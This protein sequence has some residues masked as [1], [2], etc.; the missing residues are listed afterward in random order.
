MWRTALV[1]VVCLGL[2]LLAMAL[3]HVLGTPAP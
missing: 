1:I 2:V 3:M